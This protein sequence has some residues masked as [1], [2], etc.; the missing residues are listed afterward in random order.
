MLQFADRRTYK[1]SLCAY[2]APEFSNTGLGF[3]NNCTVCLG[4][5]GARCYR[6]AWPGKYVHINQHCLYVRPYNGQ[7]LLA[8]TCGTEMIAYAVSSSK[9][10]LGHIF[11][12]NALKKL[13]ESYTFLKPACDYVFHGLAHEAL[14]TTST[15]SA[16]DTVY[17]LGLL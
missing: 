17:N 3:G 1:T 2:L 11:P 9:R 14:L 7:N 16:V 10:G 15:T 12:S 13:H 8:S 6:S 5:C 4:W